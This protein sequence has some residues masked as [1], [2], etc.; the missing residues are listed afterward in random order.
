MS[1]Q[2]PHQVTLVDST[3]VVAGGADGTVVLVPFDESGLGKRQAVDLP[4][5][6]LRWPGGEVTTNR[7]PV[8]GPWIGSVSPIGDGQV[9]A[10][11]EDQGT[12]PSP[13]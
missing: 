11:S 2:P 3:A 10:I 8:R 9:L 7:G 13:T 5:R 4:V 12:P 1:G 6:E